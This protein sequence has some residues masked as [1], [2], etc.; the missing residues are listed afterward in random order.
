MAKRKDMTNEERVALLNSKTEELV[1]EQEAELVTDYDQALREYRLENTPYKI[2]FKGRVF[3][4]PRSVPFAFSMFAARHC[5]VSRGG[6]VIFE[7]PDDKM[8]EFI[9][10]M[11]GKAFLELLEESEDVDMN[12]IGTRL[13]P[14]ILRKWGMEINAPSAP[15]KNV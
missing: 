15:S 11:F 6:K 10:L 9:Q 2:K 13:I 14:D 4:V 8:A 12:F 7:I 1:A 3:E 5:M